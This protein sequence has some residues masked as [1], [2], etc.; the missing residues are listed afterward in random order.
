MK[1]KKAKKKQRKIEK[2][3]KIKLSGTLIQLIQP[4]NK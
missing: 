3:M 4:E 2:M 1:Q